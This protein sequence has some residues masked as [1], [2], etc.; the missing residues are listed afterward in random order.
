ME[1]LKIIRETI[2][3]SRYRMSQELEIPQSQYKY[4]EEKAQMIQLKLLKKLREI[5]FKHG[6]PTEAMIKALESEVK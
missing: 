4:L 6:I 3:Y 1:G 2:K 5:C